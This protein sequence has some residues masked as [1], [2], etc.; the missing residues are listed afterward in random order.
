MNNALNKWGLGVYT[1]MVALFSVFVAIMA[2]K[3][4]LGPIASH[5]LLVLWL[6]FVGI[7]ALW[8]L[9]CF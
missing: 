8:L 6:L 1:I 3:E 5:W 4:T 2:H 9:C 7:L